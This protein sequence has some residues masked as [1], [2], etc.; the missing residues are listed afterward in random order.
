MEIKDG[1]RDFLAAFTYLLLGPL[2]PNPLKIGVIQDI[3]DSHHMVV[4]L[5]DRLLFDLI[6][7]SAQVFEFRQNFRPL[8]FE[9]LLFC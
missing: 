1:L 3:K 7:A 9:L 8:R 2:N 5:L 4:E 6:N